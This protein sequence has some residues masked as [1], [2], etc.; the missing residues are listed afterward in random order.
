MKTT[1]ISIFLC[2]ITLCG[3]AQKVNNVWIFGNKLGIDF[4]TPSPSL[5][6][7]SI[8]SFEA[9]ASVCDTAGNLLFY[10]NGLNVWDNTHT[11]MPNGS[12]LLGCDAGTGVSGVPASASQGVVIAPILGYPKLYYVFT[13]QDQ[14]LMSAYKGELRYSIVDMTL[15]G[16]KGDIVAGKK[17]ILIDSGL[18]ERM[19]VVK[20]ECGVWLI[21]HH[22]DKNTFYSYKIDSKDSVGKPIASDFATTTYPKQYMVGQIRSSPDETK[23]A[24]ATNGKNTVELFDFDKTTGKLSALKLIES[25]TAST[26]GVEF[27]ADNSKLY[28]LA[29]SGYI[30]QYDLSLF[31][32]LSAVVASKYVVNGTDR[33]SG[34]RL[35][36]DG[37]IYVV[38][39]TTMNQISVIHAPHLTGA[40]CS[41]EINKASLKNTNTT[42][43]MSFG[44]KTV[45]LDYVSGS[46]KLDTLIC[47][48]NKLLTTGNPSYSSYL[49]N[50]GDTSRIRVLTASGTYWRKSSYKCLN[51]IDSFIINFS[52]KTTK[53]SKLDTLICE[54]KTINFSID[55]SYS[56]V[57][58]NDLDTSRSKSISTS[59]IYYRQSEK[60]CTLF[61]DSFKVTVKKTDTT[62]YLHDTVACFVSQIAV[63]A[64][65]LADNYLW[66]DGTINRAN[67]LQNNELKWVYAVNTKN[68]SLRIDS[69]A[70]RSIQFSSNIP[71]T[72]ICKDE[73]ITIDATVA[74][75]SQ[76][77]WHN[78]TSGN[79]FTTKSPGAYWV[80]I[81]IANCTITDSFNIL[82]KQFNLN[83]GADKLLCQG[84]SFLI[85]SGVNNA[86]YLWSN[87]AIS[88]N[89]LVKEKGTYTLSVSK[90]GCT[91]TDE[92]E[93][94]IVQCDYCISIPNAFTPN[95]DAKNDQ[96]K[97]I[98][99]CPILNYELLIFNRYGQE[100]FKTKN[101]TAAWDGTFSNQEEGL[102]VYYYL[103]KVQF[104]TPNSIEQIYKGDLTLIR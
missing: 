46:S 88:P 74:N 43:Y 100:V 32:S 19:I 68:C 73:S 27:T 64:P 82:S 37:K 1:L 76:Y 5:I 21:T 6:A 3:K 58:W 13:L 102:G 50:D 48:T 65:I 30:T 41:L 81:S 45:S 7:S 49:W 67:I 83:L 53:T 40:L 10:S 95:N 104:D 59:G 98:F 63:N 14:E 66:S 62:Q 91:E 96:F 72:F 39:P 85:E 78:G 24:F 26:Y 92:I 79:T 51:I 9:S 38:S 29:I 4:N 89:L 11:V 33:F 80:Q 23:I 55:N 12:G 77:K 60:N 71:D 99:N 75:A 36:P 97:P 42:P 17:N 25:G 57:L 90:D 94:D 18:S 52:S 16:G 84:E 86:S 15:N 34:L 2:M 70:F 47:D 101:S 22:N 56:K 61:I 44:N 28:T 35:G 69:F 103:I 8:K 93:I 20:A 54:G 31:P 87:G